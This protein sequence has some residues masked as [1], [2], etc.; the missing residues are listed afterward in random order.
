MTGAN[1]DFFDRWEPAS[2]P[3]ATDIAA[4][5]TELTL[6][7]VGRALFGATLVDAAERLRPAVAMG[8]RVAVAA[9]RLQML[10]GLP[11]WFIDA[12]GSAVYRTTLPGRFDQLR[13]AMHMIDDVVNE[14]IDS[15]TAHGGSLDDDLLGLLLAARD[16]HGQAMSRRQVRDEL[17]TIMLAGHETTAS[18]L[19]WL[20][21]LLAQHPE[22]M[23]RMTTEIRD[24][25][26]DRVPDAGDV[27]RLPWTRA[28][29]QEAMRLYPPAWVLE[30]EARIDDEL[31]GQRVP[32]GA[33][34]IFPVHLIH[35]DQ[36][37]WPNAD[38]FDPGRFL[39]GAP[40]PERGTYLP[41]GAGRR[42]CVGATFA[43]TEGTLIAAML[44]Q[45]FRLELDAEAQIVPS[46]TVTLRPRGGLPMLVT[47]R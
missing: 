23:E 4:A 34:V 29:L 30:R 8:M 5:M 36:R 46:A 32:R 19:A 45:R 2:P 15:R 40:P 38:L 9:A 26:G 21:M 41:F 33:T 39:P 27:A 24:S 35:R 12:A 31:D 25:L 42:I 43:L 6:D 16:D 47:A 3:E 28:A 14:I 20:W 13:R 37:W 18:A 22:A 11:A 10:L 1:S 44:V 17:V 7:V